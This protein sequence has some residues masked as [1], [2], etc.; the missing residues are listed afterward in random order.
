MEAEA[1]YLMD[2]HPRNVISRLGEQKAE[3]RASFC[4]IKE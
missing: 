1:V 4:M 2:D 3:D